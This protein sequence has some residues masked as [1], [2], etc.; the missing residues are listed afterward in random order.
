MLIAGKAIG[1]SKGDR[2]W[3]KGP[4]VELL[5]FPFIA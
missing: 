3:C 5:S 2:R 4:E 1:T